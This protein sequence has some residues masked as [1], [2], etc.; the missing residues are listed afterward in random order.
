MYNFSNE[1]VTEMQCGSNISYI[2]NESHLLMSTEYKVMQNMISSCFL[3]CMKMLYNGKTQLYYLT[4]GMKSLDMM[5]SQ[6]NTNNS[7]LIFNNLLSGVIEVKNNGFLS[8]QNMIISLNH[9]YIDPVTYKVYFIYL[10]IHHRLYDDEIS[11]EKELR[12]QLIQLIE[13]I[14]NVNLA[15]INQLSSDL[16]NYMF[17]LEEVYKRFKADLTTKVK[18]YKETDTSVPKNRE[19]SLHIVAMNAPM[20]VDIEITKNDFVIGKSVN[21]ADGII[22]FNKMI[23]RQHCKVTKIK[24][25]YYI[26][27]LNS[28]NGT[29][30]NNIRLGQLEQRLLKNG[31]IIRL[32]NSD[33]KVVIK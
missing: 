16:N 21:Y 14:P 13:Q 26:S 6:L 1:N 2:L 32:A 17:T 28:A 24:N 33:F 19:V 9:I 23:S 22:S 15:K 27:D 25:Q 31:D 20:T 5:M 18:E 29:Y 7:V 10:P 11:F 4:S 3:K 8:C 30:V 12:N